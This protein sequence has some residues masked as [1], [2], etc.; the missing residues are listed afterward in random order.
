MK[1]SAKRGTLTTEAT[2]ALLDAAAQR[3]KELDIQVHISVMDSSAN[4]VGWLSLEG[5]PR[6]AATTA[7]RKSFT[8]VNTGMSTAES[9][10]KEWGAPVLEVARP[11]VPSAPLAAIVAG[12]KVTPSRENSAVMSAVVAL[13]SS[14]RV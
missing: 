9:H 6:I 10:R 3:A 13:S 14:V 2:Q 1:L 4:V 11:V 7:H 8:A 5:A 12:A